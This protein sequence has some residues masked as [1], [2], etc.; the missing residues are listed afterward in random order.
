MIMGAAQPLIDVAVAAPPPATGRAPVTDV[1]LRQIVT[2]H[3]DFVWRCLRRLGV[4]TSD[5]DD[6][7]QQVLLVLTNRLTEVP[8]EN[9]RAYLF[10]TASRVAANYRR[11][12][13]RRHRAHEQMVHVPPESTLSQEQLSDQL[14]ARALLDRVMGNMPDELRDVFI[15]FEIEEIQIKD[16]ALMLDIPL[17]TV[18]SRLRRARKYFEDAVARHKSSEDFRSGGAT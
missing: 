10:A 2:E 4:A 13:K 15:L 6:A 1:R 18:G 11:A 16:I 7:A 8:I 12:L 17:G 9:E 3:L 14:R 5:V